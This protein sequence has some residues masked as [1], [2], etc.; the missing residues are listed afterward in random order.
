LQ[1]K[2]QNL[3]VYVVCPGFVYGCGEDF[4]FDYF[5]KAWLGGIEYF[6]IR[7]NGYNFI[8][9]IHILDLIKTIRRII[10][11]KPEDKKYIFAFDKTKNPFM[12]NIISSITKKMG[13]IDVNPIKEY[14]IDEIEITNYAELKI[15]LPMKS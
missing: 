15:N 5:K 12:R 7:G 6:P 10:D 4:F 8:P 1:I 9:T 13:N 14:N 3:K 2:N 11:N